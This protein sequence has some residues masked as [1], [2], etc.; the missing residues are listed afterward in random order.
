[1]RQ[2]LLALAAAAVLAGCAGTRTVTVEKAPPPSATGDQRLSGHVVSLRRS[3][4][5]YLLRFDPMWFLSG[6]TA[7]V[8]QAEDLGTHCVP[9]AC[10]RVANDNYRLEEGHRVLT[11]LAPAHVRGTVL[12]KNAAG[13]GPFP[14]K[15]VTV[16]ELAR[17]SGGTSNLELFEPLESGVWILVHGDTVRAFAQQYVP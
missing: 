12:A 5:D 1:M 13:G 9:R 2:A 15:S 7:N 11:F 8:A 6:V 10:P 14:A 3:G 17:I 4:D 16:A